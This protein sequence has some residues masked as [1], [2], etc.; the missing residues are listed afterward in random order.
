MEE[1]LAKPEWGLKRICLGCGARF[2][3]MKRNPINCPKCD[4]KFDPNA[5]TRP[6]RSR[7]A[8]VA[9]ADAAK[10]VGAEA[11]AQAKNSESDDAELG[12]DQDV[13]VEDDEE[14][15]NSL[16]EDT[17]DLDEDDDVSG[18]IEGV[19]TEKPEEG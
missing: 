5:V 17:S 19:E 11:Q 9:A 1:E 2:Y 14:E 15:D 8:A 7:A 13:E 12:S 16:I 18:V 4:A 6:R 3:D 10:K